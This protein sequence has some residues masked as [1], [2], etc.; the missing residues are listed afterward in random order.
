MAYVISAS[1]EQ[2]PS[3]YPWC[4]VREELATGQKFVTWQ[5][6]VGERIRPEAQPQ[7]VLR[8]DYVPEEDFSPHNP[9]I[10]FV[11]GGAPCL[12]VHV[13]DL[14]EA[15]EP[16]VHQFFPV[17]IYD[18]DGTLR[19]PRRYILNTCR[20]VDAIVEGRYS[21]LNNGDCLYRAG[22]LHPLKIRRQNARNFHLW[23][24]KQTTHSCLFISNELYRRIK[25]AGF[26]V[27]D[28]GVADEV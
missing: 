5:N 8:A 19:E 13:R 26:G 17:D 11:S 2:H 14:I 3:P 21:T 28:L 12:S 16:G 1:L 25:E 15:L 24:D 4:E 20:L 10:S 22:S 18:A 9:D 27:F 7:S 6:V 23:R